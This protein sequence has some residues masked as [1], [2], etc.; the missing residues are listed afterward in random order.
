MSV[1]KPCLRCL[2]SEMDDDTAN[3]I[4]KKGISDILDR[5]KTDEKVYDE[6]LSICRSCDNLLSG[7][8]LSCGCYVE[9][10]AAIN[11]GRCPERKW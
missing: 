4:V 2:I 5:D 6:R 3:E 1:Q 11:K 8:C 7:T 10:R 9:I